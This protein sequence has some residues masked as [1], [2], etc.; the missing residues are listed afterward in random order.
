MFFDYSF[1][2]LLYS[3]CQHHDRAS[4]RSACWSLGHF[5]GAYAFR[6]AQSRASCK[7]TSFQYFCSNSLCFC[8][9]SINCVLNVCSNCLNSIKFNVCWIYCCRLP[10]YAELW[11][12]FLLLLIVFNLQACVRLHNF[13]INWNINH[14]VAFKF[15]G[16]PM[17][18]GPAVNF[19]ASSSSGDVLDDE[20][21]HTAP[22]DAQ[23]RLA[24]EAQLNST[25]S[26]LG[27]SNA[28]GASA[29]R[30]AILLSIQGDKSLCRPMSSIR[31]R[32]D[33]DDDD[34]D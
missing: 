1:A 10:S 26:R 19:A 33:A 2:S 6:F 34:D 30:A 32:N 16:M 20:R 21:F 7:C 15:R 3:S 13:I 22:V 12:H 23:E 14:N 25:Q 5:L 31:R 29:T 24:L 11:I 4:I 17:I 9:D 28:I 27:R 8:L 18:P